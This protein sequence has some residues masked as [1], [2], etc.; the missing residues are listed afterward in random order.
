MRLRRMLR[1]VRRGD[2]KGDEPALGLLAQAVEQIH[3]MVV[4]A[5]HRSV[6]G[7]S[8]LAVPNPTAY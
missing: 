4:F 2:A 3:S 5:N 6:E 7:D 8:T 1:R